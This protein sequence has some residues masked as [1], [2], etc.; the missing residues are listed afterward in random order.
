MTPSGGVP[1]AL[2]TS[3]PE[4]VRLILTLPDNSAL[5]GVI[6]RDWVRPTLSTNKS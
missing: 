4:G 2:N 1:A 3:I 6:T 5:A